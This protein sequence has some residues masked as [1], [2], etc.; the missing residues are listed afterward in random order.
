MDCSRAG[1]RLL[2]RLAEIRSTKKM[3]I[4][5]RVEYRLPGHLT[6]DDGCKP[7]LI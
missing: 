7:R 3:M 4:A 5:S 2:A 6:E 1:Y